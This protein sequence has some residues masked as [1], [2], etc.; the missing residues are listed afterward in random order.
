MKGK[1]KI[2]LGVILCLTVLLT[3]TGCF[4]KKEVTAEEFS[5]KASEYGLKVEDQS[6]DYKEDDEQ[7]ITKAVMGY[8]DNDWQVEYYELASEDYSRQLYNLARTDIEE[9]RSSGSSNTT[10]NIGNHQ[11]YSQTGDGK[12]F[13]VSRIGKTVVYV[14]TSDSNKKD[15]NAF[16]KTIKY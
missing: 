14:E 15:V 12:Y 5:D 8:S 4:N 7:R 11:K 9:A 16:L 2:I 1:K 10:I 13:V 3:M 6:E